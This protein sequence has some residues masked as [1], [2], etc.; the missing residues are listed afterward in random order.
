[1]GYKKQEAYISVSLNELDNTNNSIVNTKIAI[2]K[3]CFSDF[4]TY[5]CEHPNEIINSEILLKQYIY[6]NKQK[7]NMDCIA[8]LNKKLEEYTGASDKTKKDYSMVLK[9]WIDI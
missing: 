4:K 1:M 3:D 9:I 6:R 7:R 8:F 5:L 2:L